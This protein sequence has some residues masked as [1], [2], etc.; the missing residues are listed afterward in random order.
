MKRISKDQNDDLWEISWGVL[1]PELTL[2]DEFGITGP[3]K[4][5]KQHA[6]FQDPI[7][8]NETK[9]LHVY[10]SEAAIIVAMAEITPSVY[11]AGVKQ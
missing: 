5:L 3:F 8:R 6:T 9:T 11:A 2:V 4:D 1:D 7:Y 10:Q